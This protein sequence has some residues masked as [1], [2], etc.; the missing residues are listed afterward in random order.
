MN[1]QSQTSERFGATAKTSGDVL[2]AKQGSE[3][4]VE[5]QGNNTRSETRARRIERLRHAIANG[6]Y[7]V[8]SEAVADCL[9]NRMLQQKSM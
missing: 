2:K 5:D 4:C 6:S 8:S 3:G 7:F 9:I 1:M